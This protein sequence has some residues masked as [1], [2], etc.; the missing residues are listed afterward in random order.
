[1]SLSIMIDLCRS[2]QSVPINIPRSS[3]ISSFLS[4]KPFQLFAFEEPQ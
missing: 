1:M 4:I 3:H 2:D